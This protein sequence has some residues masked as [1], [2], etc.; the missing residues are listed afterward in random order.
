MGRLGH[1]RSVLGG[2]GASATGLVAF[3]AGGPLPAALL[4]M[5]LVGGGFVVYASA[6]LS[7]IQALSPNALRGRVTGLFALLYWGLNPLGAFLGGLVAAATSGHAALGVDGGLLLV[8]GALAV[9]LRRDVL[10]LRIDHEGRL[11]AGP[12]NVPA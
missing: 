7:L 1:G 8:T 10:G 11:E 12:A 6:S 9:L 5:A 2:L 3:G 4:A